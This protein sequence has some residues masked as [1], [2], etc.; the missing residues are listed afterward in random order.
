MTEA[1]RTLLSLRA[2]GRHRAALGLSGGNAVSVRRAI[3]RH[4]LNSSLVYVGDTPKIADVQL[5]DREWAENTDHLRAPRTLIPLRES[6]RYEVVRTKDFVVLVTLESDPTPHMNT[7]PNA[8]IDRACP[9]SAF[10]H[11]E[12]VEYFEVE[13]MTPE[14]ARDLAK[15]LNLKAAAAPDVERLPK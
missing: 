2:Y 6:W 12:H 11:L 9:A 14:T 15:L 13:V 1:K 5:A 4:R 7:V 3:H 8:F 10:E